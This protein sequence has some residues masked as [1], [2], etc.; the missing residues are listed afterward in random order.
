MTCGAWGSGLYVV[1]HSSA[2]SFRSRTPLVLN[3]LR[4]YSVKS[5]LLYFVPLLDWRIE[6]LVARPQRSFRCY[7][8]IVARGRSNALG[9]APCFREPHIT[10]TARSHGH[11]LIQVATDN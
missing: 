9:R 7:G 10:P 4:L 1:A 8:S 5:K 6:N 3:T 11:S 2:S